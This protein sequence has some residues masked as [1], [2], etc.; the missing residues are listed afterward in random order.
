MVNESSDYRCMLRTHQ[1]DW[2]RGYQIQAF[3][4]PDS[5]DTY[6]G[7]TPNVPRLMLGHSYWTTTPLSELRAMRCNCVKLWINT[8][9]ASGSQKPVS[10]GMT[11][12]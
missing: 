3:F 1:T 12:R 8:T 5:V 6:L 4:C 10:W 2:Q 11:K 7:D 9:S